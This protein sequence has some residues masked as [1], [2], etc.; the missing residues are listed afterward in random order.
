MKTGLRHGIKE[1]KSE[2]WKN[3]IINNEAVPGKNTPLYKTHKNNTPV[4]LLTTGCNT[5]IENMSK[6]LEQVS[7]PLTEGMRSRIKD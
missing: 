7:A 2:E 4:R 5:A 1:K 3:F 6:F